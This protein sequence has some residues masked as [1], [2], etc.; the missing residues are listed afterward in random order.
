ATTSASASDTTPVNTTPALTLAK[1][2]N[3]I[4]SVPGGTIAYTL[5]YQNTGNLGLAGVVL[6]ETIPA[7]TSF[8][9]AN[10]TAGWSCTGASCTWSIGSLA[11][12]AAGTATFAI[13]VAT[14][15]PAGVNQISNAATIADDNGNSASNSDTTPV[16]TTPGLSLTKSDGNA[17]TAPGGTVV[18]TLSY[19]NTGN[20]GLA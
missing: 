20:I 15:L 17:S 13:R 7:N 16:N 14:P 2:D 11:A 8:D 12:S 18:Y 5:D 19:T 10:S 1:S 3:G 9:A 4:T 6:T